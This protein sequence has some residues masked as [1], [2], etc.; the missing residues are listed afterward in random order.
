MKG[1]GRAVVRLRIPILILAVILLIPAA[2]GY[3]NT[4]TNYDILSYLPK[5]IETMKGQEILVDDFG[6]GA[7]SLI[8]AENMKEKDIKQLAEKMEAVDHVKKV[9]WYGALLDTSIPVELLPSK[10]TDMLKNGDA[11]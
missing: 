6:T 7:F 3:L 2:I 4:R 8:V 5:E 11:T 9:L 10:Y 1:F